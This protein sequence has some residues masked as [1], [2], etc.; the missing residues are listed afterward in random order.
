MNAP[1]SYNHS[2]IQA[3]RRKPHAGMWR[4][5]RR[6]SLL[7]ERFTR[8]TFRFFGSLTAIAIVLVA[9]RRFGVLA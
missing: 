2:W 3:P 5:P 9:L 6:D 1:R 4:L 8:Y 7:P